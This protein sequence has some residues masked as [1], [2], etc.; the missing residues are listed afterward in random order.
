MVYEIIGKPQ[1][2]KATGH[3]YIL[4]HFWP[5]AK[6]KE[7]G[8]PPSLVNDF[9]FSRPVTGE[10]VVRNAEG[11]ALRKDGTFVD[12][13][14]EKFNDVEQLVRETFERDLAK[15]LDEAIQRYAARAVANKYT[16]DHTGDASKPFFVDGLKIE[17][18]ASIIRMVDDSDPSGL[19]AAIN[20]GREIK[21]APIEVRK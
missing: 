2:D 6:S 5:D 4:V 12:T 17:Q 3:A 11:L 16:G 13:N 18:P 21:V 1:R 7:R 9:L 15:E 14:D 20:K 10:R 19:I 8:D